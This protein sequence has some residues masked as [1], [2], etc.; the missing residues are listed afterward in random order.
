MEMQSSAGGACGH[1]VVVRN[2][3][4]ME[5]ARSGAAR[6]LVVLLSCVSW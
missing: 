4:Q 2:R 1:A 5:G 3:G 6:A